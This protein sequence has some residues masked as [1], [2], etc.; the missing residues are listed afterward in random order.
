MN[1]SLYTHAH[2]VPMWSYFVLYLA[3]SNLNKKMMRV[4]DQV[5]RKGSSEVQTTFWK[6][7]LLIETIFDDAF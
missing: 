5:I 3:E 2:N 1:T 6:V 4:Y 7:T